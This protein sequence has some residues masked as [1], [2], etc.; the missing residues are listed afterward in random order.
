MTISGLYYNHMVFFLVFGTLENVIQQKTSSIFQNVTYSTNHDKWIL[1]I[2]KVTTKHPK[3]IGR[4]S[5]KHFLLKQQQK[6]IIDE[7]EMRMKMLCMTWTSSAIIKLKST[8]KNLLFFCDNQH[9]KYL[10]FFW[11]FFFLSHS[12]YF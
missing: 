9:E 5:R 10:Y 3:K 7:W 2:F 1:P 4:F 12:L 8:R 6:S 11:K